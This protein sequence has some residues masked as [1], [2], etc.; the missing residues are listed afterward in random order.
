VPADWSAATGRV[1][2]TLVLR[3]WDVASQGLVGRVARWA[4]RFVTLGRLGAP[5]PA[6]KPFLVE[7]R[8]PIVLAAPGAVRR[9][10]GH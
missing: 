2:L 6:E 8:E 7:G 3:T 5:V 1:E 10:E 4:M 9:P